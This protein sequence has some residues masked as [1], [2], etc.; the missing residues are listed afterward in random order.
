M[1]IPSRCCC[2]AV[3][4][5]LSA[6]N[7]PGFSYIV[8]AAGF[9]GV[10]QCPVNTYNPGMRRQR[11]CWPCPAGYTT[12]G[13]T[14]RTDISACGEHYELVAVGAGMHA[15]VCNDGCAGV[16]SELK[17]AQHNM[18]GHYIRFVWCLWCMTAA[19]LPCCYRAVVP[20]GSYMRFPTIVAL[21]PEGQWKSWVGPDDY[22]TPCPEGATTPAQG[23]TSAQNCTGGHLLP[24]PIRCSELFWSLHV[25]VCSCVPTWHCSVWHLGV[26]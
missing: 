8:D 14:G 24:L 23:S 13:M 7:L 22:C 10:F 20:P 17:T 21:C 25:F 11:T 9:P 1:L 3:C 19:L 4:V 15:Q 12:N 6:V 5:A 16:G 2:A 18:V 26:A